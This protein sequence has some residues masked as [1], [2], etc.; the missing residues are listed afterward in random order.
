MSQVAPEAST[1]SN[2]VVD[3]AAESASA[4]PI[5]SE[6]NK[7]PSSKDATL[8][9]EESSSI[10]DN[11]TPVT[12]G[13]EHKSS[14]VEDDIKANGTEM[15]KVPDNQPIQAVMPNGAENR[16]KDIQRVDEISDIDE[17]AVREEATWREQYADLRDKIDAAPDHVQQFHDYYDLLERRIAIL[18]GRWSTYDKRINKPELIQRVDPE[19]VFA[20]SRLNLVNWEDFQASVKLPIQQKFAIEILRGEPLIHFG[21]RTAREGGTDQTNDRSSTTVAD[22]VRLEP[23]GHTLRKAPTMDPNGDAVE[24]SQASDVSTHRRIPERIRINSSPL[25]QI[26]NQVSGDHSLANKSTLVI[27][28]PYKTLLSYEE[29][30]RERLKALSGAWMTVE[31]WK[32]SSQEESDKNDLNDKSSEQ[33][34]T[35]SSNTE[36]TKDSPVDKPNFPLN[37]ETGLNR[38]KR[39]S[40]LKDRR[41]KPGSHKTS[42]LQ[43][44]KSGRSEDCMTDSPQALDHLTLLVQ[45]LD[46]YVKPIVNP[47]R[48][49][50]CQKIAFWDL[51]HLFQTGDEATMKRKKEWKGWG[52]WQPLGLRV[53]NAAGGRYYLSP[54]RSGARDIGQHSFVQDRVSQFNV[55]TYYVDFD[56]STMVP[57]SLQFSIDHYD[58]ERD[59]SELEIFP[60]E[61]ANEP[62]QSKALLVDRGRKFIQ[63]TKPRHMHCEGLDIISKEEI[64]GQVMVDFKEGWADQ[65]RERELGMLDPPRRSDRAET[66]D[67]PEGCNKGS[68]SCPHGSN[69]I[70]DDAEIDV[71]VGREFMATQR[72]LKTDFFR[73]HED[74]SDFTEDELALCNYR[75]HAY[76]LRS[77]QWG[78][79]SH[80]KV[81]SSTPR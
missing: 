26:L 15:H 68:D 57:I 1:S 12:K 5:G 28:S 38:E 70:H 79:Q 29:Q 44:L 63:F 31:E 43:C 77:R 58:G 22:Q 25:L 66:W 45:F 19:Q 50:K 51:W 52:R 78:K 49:R 54:K 73:L 2:V 67:C 72:L 76:V 62:G 27:L 53:L 37:K 34:P 71:K 24:G 13:V 33:K 21:E 6:I 65:R 36:E 59:I 74:G 40:K 4:T 61:Y 9:I 16:G 11:G 8:S 47:I 17:E 69:P 35:E 42:C 80:V 10:V 55:H 3:V 23:V 56:G 41:R 18:E 46:E 7:W 14:E 32:N 81:R 30:I 39:L 48:E 60:Y 20:I 64:D 75:V